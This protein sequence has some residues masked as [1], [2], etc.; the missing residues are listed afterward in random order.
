MFAD[1]LNFQLVFCTQTLL[2]CV[3]Y[4]CNVQKVGFEVLTAANTKFTYLSEVLAD[5]G[6]RKL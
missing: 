3:L 4:T 1:I 5:G 2:C 6:S